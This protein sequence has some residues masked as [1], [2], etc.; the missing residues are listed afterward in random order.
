MKKQTPLI[1]DKQSNAKRMK[2]DFQKLQFSYLT[3]ALNDITFK[4]MIT[5]WGDHYEEEEFAEWFDK[6]WGPPRFNSRVVACKSAE[7]VC[8]CVYAETARLKSV[9]RCR[10]GEYLLRGVSECVCVCTYTYV[11]TYRYTHRVC[12][13]ARACAHVCMHTH[14][15]TTHTILACAQ[16]RALNN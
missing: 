3:V 12:V 10:C 6:A 15:H 9:V 13:C 4:R 1:K 8:M 11:C 16:E 7:V 2:M 14:T 5:Y